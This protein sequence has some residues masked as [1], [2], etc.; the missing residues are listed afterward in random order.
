LTVKLSTWCPRPR[1]LQFWFP[2]KDILLPNHETTIQAITTIDPQ[3]LLN[4]PGCLANVLHRRPISEPGGTFGCWDLFVSF[5]WEQFFSLFLTFMISTLLNSQLLHKI[6]L[7]LGFSGISLLLDWDYIYFLYF[8]AGLWQT[9]CCIVLIT[10]GQVAPW[11]FFIP[12][13]MMC[14]FS[15]WLTWYLLL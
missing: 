6:I 4:F 10:S 13:L 5:N 12:L 8:L 9:W 15:I 14:I 1:T 2:L 3:A 7:N 11:F